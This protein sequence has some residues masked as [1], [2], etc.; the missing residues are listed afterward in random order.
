MM[1]N[2]KASLLLL[3]AAVLVLGAAAPARAELI[4]FD[5]DALGNPLI[6]PP[7]FVQTTALR[8]LYAPLGVRFVGPGPLD[9][10][11]ILDRDSNFGVEPL[12]GRNFLAV[13]R[14]ASFMG[15]GVPRDP[16][17]ILFDVAN[18]FV[19]LFASGG[20]NANTFRLDAYDEGGTLVDSDTVATAVGT[21]GE[22]RVEAGAGIARVVVTGTGPSGTFVFDNLSYQPVPEPGSL[23]L[24]GVGVAGLLGYG[25][26]RRQKA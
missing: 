22:M 7:T 10:P 21:W 14:G 2:R 20:F 6:A 4:T 26:R 13:N 8:D 19:S 16:F 18:E 12:S 5:T 11:G 1:A 15:G 3:L 24:L 9:G 17:E 25:W 23:T